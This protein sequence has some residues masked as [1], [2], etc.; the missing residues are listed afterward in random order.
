MNEGNANSTNPLKFCPFVEADVCAKNSEK[1]AACVRHGL[2]VD[3]VEGRRED[4]A[5]N[6][7]N[8]SCGSRVTRVSYLFYNTI[9]T[10]DG[11]RPAR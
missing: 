6:S 8:S 2:S 9:A 4:S 5:T 1:I 3:I 7:A 10:C 11:I